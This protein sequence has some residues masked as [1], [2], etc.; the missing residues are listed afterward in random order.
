MFITMKIRITFIIHIEGPLSKHPTNDQRMYKFVVVV[1]CSG[2]RRS[3]EFEIKNSYDLKMCAHKGVLIMC[4]NDSVR[5]Q[6]NIDHHTDI[7]GEP[8]AAHL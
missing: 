3:Q 2:I 6:S 5:G 1:L 4:Q 8:G 7:S